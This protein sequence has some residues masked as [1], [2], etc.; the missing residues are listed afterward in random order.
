MAYYD[1]QG[2]EVVA[3]S[4]KEVDAQIKA[5]ST[6]TTGK[7]KV[8]EDA[9]A[10]KTKE[11]DDLS[12]KYEDK[13]TSY[14]ELQD[15]TKADESK[16][17]EVLER[18]T[19]AYNK[20]IEDKIAKIAGEDKEYAAEIKKQLDAGVGLETNDAAAID[21]QI[22]KAQALTNIELSREVNSPSDGGGSA[23]I[24]TND[25]KRFTDTQ[26]GKDT[27]SS[28]E[29]MMGLPADEPAK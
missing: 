18:D 21:K 27:L 1:E 14:K 6:D 17:K 15:K 11:Y 29:S 16:Y 25:T 2:D 22:Q 8:A 12:S 13:K 28:L 19:T 7:V 5:A 4:Q 9:L 3:F 26:E 20:A 23:P 24:Y 10:A